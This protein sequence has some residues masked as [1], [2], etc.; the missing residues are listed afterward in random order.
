MAIYRF[1]GR[2]VPKFK[3]GT[4][5]RVKLEGSPY[6]GLIGTVK[7]IT[8]EEAGL[9]YTVDFGASGKLAPYSSFN[10]D[11]LELVE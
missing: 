5:V 6:Q 1:R 2:R 10:E 3:E 9:V 8:S 7:I 11:D 4:R